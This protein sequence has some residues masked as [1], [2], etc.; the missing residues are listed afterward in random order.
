MSYRFMKRQ[1]AIGWDWYLESDDCS[2]W[3]SQ[4]VKEVIESLE[5][6]NAKLR[7]L[8]YERAHVYAIQ[9]MTEAELRIV[10][11]NVMEDNTKLRELAWMLANC[12]AGHGC[13]YCPINGG[14][15]YVGEIDMCESVHD[16][17]R[18]LGVVE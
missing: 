13:D 7:N 14:H 8:M 5:T 6:E 16:R 2:S 4:L 18:E 9:H 3:V 1:N 15:G 12:A 17:M 11:T 10:A